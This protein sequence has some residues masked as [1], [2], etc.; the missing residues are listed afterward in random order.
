ME[1]PSDQPPPGDEERF[2]AAFA[3]WYPDVLRF[4]SRRVHPTHAEDVVAETFLVLWRR[5]AELPTDPGDGRAWA[6]GVARG[7]LLNDRR[8]VRRREALAVRVADEAEAHGG[9][10]GRPGEDPDLLARRLDLAAAWPR[11]TAADQ[12]VLA[13]AYWDDLTSPEAARVLGIS[14]VAFR[15][16]LTRARRALRRHLD[17]VG[18]TAAPAHPVP[19]GS[20]S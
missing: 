6:F 7:V 11:L 5:V 1:T 19:E 9:L 17:L 13:L 12:E 14:P 16:R 8:G 2:R 20:P 3:A 10:G 15:L 18:A 4:V